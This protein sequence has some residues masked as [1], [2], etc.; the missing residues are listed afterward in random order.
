[1]ASLQVTTTDIAN[2]IN[3]Q[4]QLFGAGQIGHRAHA[5]DV[6]DQILMPWFLR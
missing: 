5:S 6:H 2:A 1:M 3:Q 4:N